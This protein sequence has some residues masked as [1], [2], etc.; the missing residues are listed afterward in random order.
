MSGSCNGTRVAQFAVIEQE[1]EP[2]WRINVDPVRDFTPLAPAGE[3]LLPMPP[4]RVLGIS[5]LLAIGL[6]LGS[7]GFESLGAQDS[8]TCLTC[9]GDVSLW[10]TREDGARFVVDSQELAGST[11]SGM[12]CLSCHQGMTF[13][14][15]EQRPAVSCDRCHGTQAQQHAESL[16]GAAAQRGDPLA[17]TCGDCH[18]T[19]GIL[20]ERNERSPTAIVN[21][22]FLCGECHQEGTEVS[23]RREIAEDHILENYSLSIHGAGLFRRV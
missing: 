1:Y 9:H 2:A 22:P 13:P 7:G 10:G 4:A 3:A 15:S 6:L 8:E 20:P 11:H 21:I 12:E 5:L 16:H 14:H 17:P 18:G 23:E 19:H